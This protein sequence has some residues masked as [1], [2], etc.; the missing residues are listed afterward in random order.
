MNRIKG[1][2]IVMI[3]CAC[4]SMSSAAPFLDDFSTDTSSAY[5]YSNSFNSGGSFEIAGGTLSITTGNDNTATVSTVDPVPFG[6]G[7]SLGVDVEGITS[8]EG[9]FLILGVAPGQPS[10][11]EGGYRWRR[12]GV[13]GTGLRIQRNGTTI[14][15]GT[16]PELASPATLWIDRLSSNTFEFL[17]QL[18]GEATRTSFGTDTHATLDGIFDL[19]IGMQAFDN[20]GDTFA[21]D[22]LRIVRTASLAAVPEPSSMVI[23]LLAGVAGVATLRRRIG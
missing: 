22:N 16:D 15:N 11:A 14:I 17:I 12:D 20:P 5:V 18:E 21:F 13:G 7:E 23:A 1:L 8:P 4:A 10:A 2:A 6:V 19:H 9:V 3:G